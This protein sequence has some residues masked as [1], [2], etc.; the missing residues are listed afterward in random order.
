MLPL[1]RGLGRQSPGQNDSDQRKLFL[2]YA[3]GTSWRCWADH[4]VELSAIDVGLENGARAGH[5]KYCCTETRRADA[6][7]CLAD[8]RVDP[9]SRIPTWSRQHTSW[10]RAH[11]GRG[12]RQE[13][14]H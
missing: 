11:G 5:W 13:H 7:D 12:H 6:A 10:L 3:V 14:G 8:W 1:L 9:G 2:L 4:T